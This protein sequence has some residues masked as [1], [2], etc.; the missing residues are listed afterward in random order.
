MSWRT[1]LIVLFFC[2]FR[3]TMK[4]GEPG[5]SGFPRHTS[6]YCWFPR[7]IER[8][9][10]SPFRAR[11]PTVAYVLIGLLTR[12]S[13]ILV[14]PPRV[15]QSS[16]IRLIDHIWYRIHLHSTFALEWN[17]SLVE[18][19]QSDGTGWHI[20]RIRVAT[21]RAWLDWSAGRLADAQ[22]LCRSLCSHHRRSFQASVTGR[23]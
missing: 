3:Q 20:T 21:K 16:E 4:P 22:R 10:Q 2:F 19:V 5:R 18:R 7:K 11:R 12:T 9:R 23:L 13:L 6:K 8:Y 14:R 15:I 1:N 17:V